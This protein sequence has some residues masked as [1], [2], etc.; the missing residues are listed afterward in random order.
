MKIQLGTTSFEAMPLLEI[1]TYDEAEAQI[2]A[3]T[4]EVKNGWT[5]VPLAG[6]SPSP[7]TPSVDA[8]VR[9]IL[10]GADALSEEDR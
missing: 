2:Q 6:P 5:C 4:P 7:A 8:H 1:D 3:G 10:H 9:L